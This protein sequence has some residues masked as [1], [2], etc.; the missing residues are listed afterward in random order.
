M[1]DSWRLVAVL[2]AFVLAAIPL[3]AADTGTISGLVVDRHGEPLAGLTVA[4]ASDQLPTGRTST[5]DANG[6]Y[7]FEYLIPGEYRVRVDATGAARFERVALV[8]IGR[9]TQVDVVVGVA[10]AEALTVTAIQPKVDVRSP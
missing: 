9:S 3:H 5:T 6:L 10:V 4:I 1:V 7:Q 2:L 8:E